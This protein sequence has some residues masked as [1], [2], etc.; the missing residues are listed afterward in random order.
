MD[1]FN[2]T[3]R[4]TSGG[5]SLGQVVEVW[6]AQNVTIGG[7]RETDV[8]EFTAMPY[9]LPSCNAATTATPVAKWPSTPAQFLRGQGRSGHTGQTTS[10]KL[11]KSIDSL[12]FIPVN[13][14]VL[15]VER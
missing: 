4:R 11:P 6:P 7:W 13:W 8:N 1:C 9:G 14:K 3:T 5:L 10:V 15:A 12:R 2:S